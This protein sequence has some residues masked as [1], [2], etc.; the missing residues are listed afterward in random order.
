MNE[1]RGNTAKEGKNRKKQQKKEK[2]KTKNG[3]TKKRH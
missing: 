2:N 3:E 1:K